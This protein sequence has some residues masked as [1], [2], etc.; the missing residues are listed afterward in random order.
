MGMLFILISGAIQLSLSSFLPFCSSCC[1][2][3]PA[4][5]DA[6]THSNIDVRNGHG[7]GVHRMC[8]SLSHSFKYISRGNCVFSFLSSFESFQCYFHPPIHNNFQFEVKCFYEKTCFS[9][10][11]IMIFQQR[12]LPTVQCVYIYVLKNILDGEIRRKLKIE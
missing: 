7:I 11:C 5:I 9:I 6:Q 3:L 1:A 2:Y 10:V 4:S 12:V 8:F